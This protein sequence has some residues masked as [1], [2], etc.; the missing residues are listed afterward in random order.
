MHHLPE[1]ELIRRILLRRNQRLFRADVI[2]LDQQQSCLYA[3]HIQRQHSGGVNIELLARVHQRVPN[4]DGV[5][6][7]MSVIQWNPYFVAEVA[8]VSGARNIHRHAGNLAHRFSEILQ[9]R[10]VGLR[11]RL[12]KFR[13][14]R[15]LQ[16]QSRRLLG[17]VL[18]LNVHVQ[19]V[20][21]EPAQARIG[22]RPAIFI[23][24]EARNRTVVD[25]LSVLIA[26]TGVNNLAHGDFVDVARDHAVHQFGRI[27]AGDQILIERRNI[28]QRARI[29]D[30][31]VLVLVVHFV[32]TDRVVSRP[33][34]VIQ[35]VAE[36][37]GS[38]V[39]CSSNG[40]GDLVRRFGFPC[41]TLCPLWLRERLYH[42]GTQGK[43]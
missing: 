31:V 22:G 16:R 1:A 43:S 13:G 29:T 20:L 39:K 24:F 32:H 6:P 26:P 12:Q 19:A 5:I 33:L 4:R 9:I 3:R 17:D 23:F 18:D 30:R 8:G 27:L 25:D 35:T 10:N 7:V 28:N 11:D 2:D 40:Q 41:E 34:A 14:G 37:E 21:P 38:L 36:G 42:R 15:P